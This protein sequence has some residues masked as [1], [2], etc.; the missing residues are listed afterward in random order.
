MKLDGNPLDFASFNESS[1]I[2]SI[3]TYFESGSTDQLRSI[4][5]PKAL[6]RFKVRA[7]SVWGKCEKQS[8]DTESAFAKSSVGEQVIPKEVMANLLYNLQNLRKHEREEEE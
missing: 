8:L 3:D 1:F 5:G 7:D 6:Q 2:V 4:P